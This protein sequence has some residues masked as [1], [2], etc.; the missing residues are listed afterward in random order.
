MNVLKPV[1]PKTGSM[2]GLVPHGCG[3]LMGVDYRT[4]NDNV[5]ADTGRSQ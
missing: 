5:N 3:S 4:P 1:G 2:Q